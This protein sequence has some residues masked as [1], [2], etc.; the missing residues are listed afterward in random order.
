HQL[1]QPN[2]LHHFRERS[3][4]GQIQTACRICATD[5]FGKR[6]ILRRAENGEPKLRSRDCQ[7]RDQFSE[8]FCRP[9]LVRPASAG[10]EDDPART[11]DRPFSTDCRSDRRTLRQPSEA[12]LQEERRVPTLRVGAKS[13]ARSW[14]CALRTQ[15][16]DQRQD[17]Q[18]PV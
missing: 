15:Q 5:D 9:A 10:L 13:V 1:T 11:C 16:T 17:T 12:L 14:G 3:F 4:S 7:T 18:I 6:P 2:P 8:T